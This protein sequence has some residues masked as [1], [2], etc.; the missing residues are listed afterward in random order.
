MDPTITLAVSAA[1]P[2]SSALSKP[3]RKRKKEP[4]SPPKKRIKACVACA[5]R[6]VACRGLEVPGA[7]RCTSC[8]LH[9]LSCSGA[10]G[11]EVESG[12]NGGAPASAVAGVVKPREGAKIKQLRRTSGSAPQHLGPS[13]ST[14]RL[15][16]VS[17]GEALSWT[18]VTAA[19][20]EPSVHSTAPLTALSVHLD[21]LRHGRRSGVVEVEQEVLT[22][23]YIAIG[24]RRSQHSAIIGGGG[25]SPLGTRRET[26]CRALAERAITAVQSSPSIIDSPSVRNL[27]ILA[28]VRDM[29]YLV[30]PTNS[31]AR[32]VVQIAHRQSVSLVDAGFVFD[33]K[34]GLKTN[35]AVLDA[36][37]ASRMGEEP[38]L[39][40][41]EVDR[42]QPRMKQLVRE[43]I[44]NL[45]QPLVAPEKAFHLSIW[46]LN[47]QTFILRMLHRL[48]RQIRLTPSAA[49]TLLSTVWN[50]IDLAIS[51][52]KHQ[53]YSPA[54]SPSSPSSPPSAFIPPELGSRTPISKEELI[55]QIPDI[56]RMEC[57]LL[58]LMERVE[59][60][61]VKE[62]LRI[63][64]V[65]FLRGVKWMAE[66]FS[67]VHLASSAPNV[68]WLARRLELLQTVP[69]WIQ[70]IIEGAKQKNF[71]LGP[72]AEAR[73][74][75]SSVRTLLA[76]LGKAQDVFACLALAYE[77]LQQAVEEEESQQLAIQLVDNTVATI[78][79]SQPASSDPW[80]HTAL[81]SIF[82]AG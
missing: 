2:T 15:S 59:G 3:P 24:S 18:L 40:E 55:G 51:Y 79:G 1:A 4:S 23:C 81:Q 62:V 43:A 38:V 10:V 66:G 80:L 52:V 33:F 35:Y 76:S 49:L 20:E 67:E 47:L 56:L 63:Q 17:M 34:A 73:F 8:V 7:R 5:S 25:P 13:S 71:G 53:L 12:E 64:R 68:H 48:E 28:V 37:V 74:S 70:L 50:L 61:A 60:E 21:F 69:D 42:Y 75:W 27:E 82:S 45:G 57:E 41:W 46:I 11:K 65:R 72:L 6:K 19:F 44:S 9:G 58:A 22:A 78:E 77:K 31:F 14:A 16:D 39:K 36:R 30:D 29:I 32:E 26:A 54:P